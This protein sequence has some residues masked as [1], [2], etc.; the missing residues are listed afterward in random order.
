[1]ARVPVHKLFEMEMKLALGGVCGVGGE[2]GLVLLK[3]R[4]QRAVPSFK[5][6]T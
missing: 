3:F 4:V 5:I 1:M 2:G 6:G